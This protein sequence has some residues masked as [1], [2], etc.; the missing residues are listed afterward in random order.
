MSNYLLAFRGRVEAEE[1]P[2]QE[3]VWSKWFRDLGPAIVDYGH[4]VGRFCMVGSQGVVTEAGGAD[5]LTGYIVV[6]ARMKVHR[7]CE[8]PRAAPLKGKTR[9]GADRSNRQARR[10]HSNLITA[11]SR[12]RQGPRLTYICVR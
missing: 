9:A 10:N 11:A 7:H 8:A 3:E 1:A 2:A 6:A 5:P 4:R 12:R